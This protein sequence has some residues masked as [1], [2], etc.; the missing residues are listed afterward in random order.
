[1]IHFFKKLRL[2]LLD[3]EESYVLKRSNFFMCFVSLKIKSSYERFF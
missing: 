3:L 1:M 2:F